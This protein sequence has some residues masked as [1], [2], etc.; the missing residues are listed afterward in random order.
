MEDVK[1]VQ[2]DLVIMLE[3]EVACLLHRVEDD[4]MIA[5]AVCFQSG[6]VIA[7]AFTFTCNIGSWVK[8]MYSTCSATIVHALVVS[9]FHFLDR[10]FS[11]EK[12]FEEF[13]FRRSCQLTDATRTRCMVMTHDDHKI[14]KRK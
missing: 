8:L 5:D 1:V 6:N 2:S 3:V 13:L 7:V 4:A 9:L 12:E 11:D 14:S 10:I